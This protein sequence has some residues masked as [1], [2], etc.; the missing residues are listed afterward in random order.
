MNM[1]PYDVRVIPRK[2]INNFFIILKYICFIFKILFIMKLIKYII[3]GIIQGLTEPLPISSS[4]HIFIIKHL[5]NVNFI[6]DL[7]YEIILNAGSMAS[8]LIIYRRKLFSL[9]KGFFM[10]LKSKDE[11]YM[12]EFKYSLYI[13]IGVFPVCILGLFLKDFIER[14]LSM[15]FSIVGISF[16]ITGVFLYLVRNKNNN[17]SSIKLSDALYIGFVQMIALIPGISRSGSTLIAGLYSGLSREDA[18]DYSFMLYIPISI[19]TTLLGVIELFNSEI[20]VIPYVLGFFIS[21]IVSL[22]TLK[23][24]RNIV[25]QGKLIYFS[26]YCIIIGLFILIFMV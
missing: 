15:S 4:G 9:I 14:T 26:V 6:N 1:R 17:R 20:D 8:I 19:C 2:Y 5:L 18:F 23:W 7:N 16:I 22:F 13:I 10:Y 3:L 11:V 24:F 21:L 12:N 25:R